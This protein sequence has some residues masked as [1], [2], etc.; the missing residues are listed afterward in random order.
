MEPF[1]DPSSSLSLWSVWVA[2]VIV[3]S[4]PSF[5]HSA[6][7]SAFINWGGE[8]VEL[9]VASA[10]GLELVDEAHVLSAQ[11]RQTEWGRL[12]DRELCSGNGTW[13]PSERK[14]AARFFNLIK[15]AVWKRG[16]C[17]NKWVN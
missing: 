14:G 10:C 13:L 15:I 6:V 16:S 2:P 1:A 9:K 7:L 11:I 17:F 3:P 8:E 5:T 4:G 12:E